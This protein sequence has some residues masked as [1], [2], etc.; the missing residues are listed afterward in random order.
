MDWSF[1]LAPKITD[2]EYLLVLI[3]DEVK[4]TQLVSR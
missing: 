3:L 2:W 1:R 4:S